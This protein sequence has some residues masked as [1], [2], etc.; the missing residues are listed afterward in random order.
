MTENR[1]NWLYPEAS[2]LYFPHDGFIMRAL[3]GKQ[4]DIEEECELLN[5]YHKGYNECRDDVLRLEKENEQLRQE[6]KELKKEINGFESCSHNWGILYDEAKNK[7][8]ELSKENKELKY[9][10][11]NIMSDLDDYLLKSRSCEEGLFEKDREI[12]KL[13]KENKELKKRDDLVSSYIRDEGSITLEKYNE[14][15]D[16]LYKE[17]KK[18]RLIG[19]E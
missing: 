7:V 2:G 6:N 10:N 9:E 8:E 11:V 12:A 4:Y 18:R 17:W 5:E 19:N 13:E 16:Y 15:V 3:D 1:K 14:I